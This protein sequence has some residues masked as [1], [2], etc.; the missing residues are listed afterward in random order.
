M[1]S[2]Y[3]DM[4]KSLMRAIM[5]AQLLDWT[6][7]SY[8]TADTFKMHLEAWLQPYEIRYNSPRQNSRRLKQCVWKKKESEYRK[9]DNN[10]CTHLGGNK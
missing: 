10:Y 9:S 5:T 3:Y 4:Y 7:G 6:P 2:H 1:N 8:W